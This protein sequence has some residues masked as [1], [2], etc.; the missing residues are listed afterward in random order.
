MEYGDARVGWVDKSYEE[1]LLMAGRAYDARDGEEGMRVF[2]FAARQHPVQFAKDLLLST[3][4]NWRNAEFRADVR[5]VV[6]GR[7]NKS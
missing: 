5:K 4:G 7:E 2:R 3:L 1:L 6:T